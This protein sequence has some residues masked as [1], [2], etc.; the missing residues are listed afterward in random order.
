LADVLS[1]Y[2]KSLKEKAPLDTD[3]FQN[4]LV[5]GRNFIAQF[6]GREELDQ[7]RELWWKLYNDILEDKELSNWFSDLRKFVEEILERPESLTEEARKKQAEELTE[8]GRAIL[9]KEKWRNDFM[10]LKDQF[11]LLIDRIRT[12]ST[13][14][15]W[16]SKL[17][18]FGSDLLFNEQGLPDIFVLEDSVYQLKNLVVPLFKRTLENIP[19]K[20][21]DVVTDTYDVR[22]EDI[23][24]DATTFMP[25]NLDFKLLSAS[26]LD[27]KDNSKDLTRH[28][29]QLKVAHIKPQ[30]RNLKFYYRRKTFPKIED[31]GIADFTL[32]GDGGTINV[33]WT[34]E[35]G[36]K[37]QPY[38]YLSRVECTIDKLNIHII[39]EATKHDWLDTIMA[40]LLSNMIK[41]K[42]ANTL[43]EYL[44]GKLND[45]NIK[46]NEWF[47]SRPAYQLKL[48]ADQAMKETYQKSKIQQ[49][50]QSS[51]EVK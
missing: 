29:M 41:N 7:F 33:I 2:M 18:K 40:P 35:S 39:G 47:S 32:K 19:I 36:A 6:T 50:Q 28:Q 15:E 13:T 22:V 11:Q 27:F 4:A 16:T 46:L 23:L 42:I 45:A 17:E 5:D 1:D 12:D 37:T 26:H 34:V 44:K 10:K 9:Q 30:F 51:F 38:A 24:F 49:Q 3:H 31:Y 43:E 25:E 48:K 20:R 14:Q 21:I 8:R